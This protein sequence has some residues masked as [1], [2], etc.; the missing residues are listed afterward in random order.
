M[1]PFAMLLIAGLATASSF[2]TVLQPVPSPAQ[3]VPAA[4]SQELAKTYVPG[5][6]E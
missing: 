6:G 4:P 1:K 5:L 3:T 2:A